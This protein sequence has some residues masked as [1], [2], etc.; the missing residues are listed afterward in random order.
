MSILS[1]SILRTQTQRP[2]EGARSRERFSDA[3][4]LVHRIGEAAS[5]AGYHRA[6][7]CRCTIANGMR[8]AVG[9]EKL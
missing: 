2:E 1:L 4:M 8:A 5:V 7:Q 3:R 6:P 9:S